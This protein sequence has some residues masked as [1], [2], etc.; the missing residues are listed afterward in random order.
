MNLKLN[1]KVRDTNTLI[2]RP[3]PYLQG[4]RHKNMENHKINKRNNLQFK[5]FAKSKRIVIK[6]IATYK[7]KQTQ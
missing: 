2:T 3:K 6:T 1:Y 4:K 7:K 5:A